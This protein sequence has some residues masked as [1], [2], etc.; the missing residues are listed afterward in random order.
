MKATLTKRMPS[1]SVL[2]PQVFR[3]SLLNQSLNQS[4]RRSTIQAY[5]LHNPVT[6]RRNKK[7]KENVLQPA[8]LKLLWTAM[9]S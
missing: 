8:L 9:S 1:Y 5:I 7:E 4:Q 6:R 3:N 2:S